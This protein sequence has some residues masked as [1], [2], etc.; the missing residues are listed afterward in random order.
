M[1]AISKK[2]ANDE[3][4][5]LETFSQRLKVN[6]DALVLQRERVSQLQAKVDAMNNIV[7]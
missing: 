6:D 5:N 3:K 1:E 7:H 2:L 4:T